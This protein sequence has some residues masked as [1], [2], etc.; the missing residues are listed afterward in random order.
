VIKNE[1]GVYPTA[2]YSFA[3]L[4]CNQCD[5][6]AC[7]DVC[8]V[9][10]TAKQA[11]GIVTIDS[12]KCIGCRYCQ[13]ACPY[14]ART[15]I[16]TNTAAYYPGLGLT[17]F[18]KVKYP[19]HEVGTVEKCTFCSDRLAQGL[20]PACVGTCPAEAMTFG[21][22]DDPNSAVAKLVAARNPQPLKPEAGTHPKVFYI[23]G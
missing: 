10:A 6:P 2:Y 17:P 16:T 18:E 21:D 8:P 7:A 5:D 13:V 4:L 11:N 22:L 1:V 20:Q 19:L 15:F 12:G 3:P 9:G 14:D 23:S